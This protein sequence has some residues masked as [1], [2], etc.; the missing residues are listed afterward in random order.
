[1]R[2]ILILVILFVS[3]F[4]GVE[5]GVWSTHCENK[6]CN[7]SQGRLQIFWM[8]EKDQFIETMGKL[9]GIEGLPLQMSDFVT[10]EKRIT[11]MIDLATTESERFGN[12]MSTPMS[13]DVGLSKSK[14]TFTENVFT[15][16]L[17]QQHSKT[18]GNQLT[19]D[20]TLAFVK[21][22]GNTITSYAYWRERGDIGRY[23]VAMEDILQNYYDENLMLYLQ[24]FLIYRRGKEIDKIPVDTP[25]TAENMDIVQTKFMGLLDDHYSDDV[26]LRYSRAYRALSRMAEWEAEDLNTE[27]NAYVQYWLPLFC[28]GVTA[29]EIYY[30]S[31]SSNKVTGFTKWVGD[32]KDKVFPELKDQKDRYIAS[33]SKV[34][35]NHYF[36]SQY[37]EEFNKAMEDND[38]SVYKR[39]YCPLLLEAAK[40][41]AMPRQ[42]KIKRWFKTTLAEYE[43]PIKATIVF[44]SIFVM[45]AFLIWKFVKSIVQ[46]RQK[47]QKEQER[48]RDYRQYEQLLIEQEQQP[49]QDSPKEEAGDTDP[50][51][52]K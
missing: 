10:T 33:M 2:I 36:R 44:L 37:Q 29:K 22:Y 39:V 41:A 24:A 48:E 23:G 46:R 3:V 42:E 12:R 15:R 49:T 52:N 47:F 18:M 8:A 34:D 13:D 32:K 16:R 28:K 30:S 14:E 31:S 17:E 11:S 38:P 21:W 9:T 43:V 19:I 35:N 6:S 20:Y 1:M 25:M 40:E 7:A 50:T 4:Q 45:L 5:A 26:Q 51:V 27:Y